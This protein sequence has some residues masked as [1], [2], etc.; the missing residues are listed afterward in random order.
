METDKRNRLIALVGAVALHAAVL[1]VLLCLYL[2]YTGPEERK[3]PPED[4]S[5]LLLDGQ[6]VKYG[7]IPKP[8]R[9]EVT[10]APAAQQEAAPE[11]DDMVD[12]GEP[13]P[14]PAPVISSTQESPMKVQEKPKPE[15]TGPTAEELAERERVKKQKEAAQQ[16]SKRVNF[17]GTKPGSASASG[18][19]GSPNGNASSGALSGT[20]GTN[21]KGRTLDSWSKPSGSETGTIV[22][23]VRVNRQGQVVKASYSSGNGAVAGNLTARRNCEQAALKSKFSVNLDAPAEQLGTITYRFE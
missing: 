16:I 5:E 1:V 13:A 2:R 15:K 10:P 7:D 14:E 21:L 19:S 17:G 12:A 3:W 22:I 6:Y 18:T 23:A 8:D 9:N 20:P 4:T 11:A